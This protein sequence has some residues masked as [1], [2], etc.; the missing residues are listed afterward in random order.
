MAG[1]VIPTL[2]KDFSIMPRLPKKP[3]QYA[4][5]ASAVGCAAIAVMHPSPAGQI[6]AV[7][8]TAQPLIQ[9]QKLG[10]R[11]GN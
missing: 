5:I 3:V 2:S 8:L 1:A 11:D 4:L 9:L 10:G 6:A 7:A